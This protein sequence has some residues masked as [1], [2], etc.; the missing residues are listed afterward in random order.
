MAE[1]WRALRT[2]KALQAEQS[3]G[4]GPALATRPTRRLA[5]PPLVHRPQ[6]DEPERG[7]ARRPEYLP[8]EPPPPGALHEPAAAW[9]PNEPETGSDR[10]ALSRTSP[11]PHSN[12]SGTEGVKAT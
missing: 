9:I 5:T 6:P 2:L 8:T 3:L 7:A 1:F 10:H 4:T 11:K 12:S